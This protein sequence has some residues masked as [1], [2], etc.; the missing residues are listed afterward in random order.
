MIEL[1][2]TKK[3][4][5]FLRLFY[6]T[7][8][9]IF[10][11]F[12]IFNL[13]DTDPEVKE[14]AIEKIEPKT[15]QFGFCEDTLKH[16]TGIVKK[17]ETLS[18]ILQNL[19]V[20]LI[21]IAEIAEASKN[22]FDVRKIR[23]GKQFHIYS[24]N[25]SSNTVKY[26]IYEK[27]PINFVIY[28]LTDSIKIS[29]GKKEVVTKIVS[30]QATIDHSLYVSLMDANTS[31]ELAV[32]LSQIY[33]WQID[34]YHLQ[35]GDHFKVIYEKEFI[36]TQFVGI[37]RILG[38][39]FS[40]TGKNFYAIPFVQDSVYQYFDEDGNSLRKAFLKAPLEFSRISSRYSHRRFHPVLKRYRPHLGV[41]YA[42]PIGT[43]VR[44]TGDG[45]VIETGYKNSNGRYI[46]IKHNS[47]YTTI[48]LHLSK[49]T[50]GIKRGSHVTQ[51]QVIGYVGS[52]GLSTGP[53]L[54][55]RFYVN[56]NP[57]D[58]LKVEVPPSHP[59]KE[60]LR[61]EYEIQKLNVLNELELLDL[62]SEEKTDEPV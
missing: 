55:Y 40:S 58:P 11:L 54:D 32:K 22:I 13:L 14:K 6:F 37:G 59:V 26:F 48:Y 57:V 33:A 21:T 12:L 17:N 20:P 46:K 9:L 30:T 8:T 31:P 41:D 45:I 44:T 38:A 29:T 60:E 25:D 61:T 53:H 23:A 42:A 19:A 4:V 35:K 24:N 51:G 1:L 28:E 49:F 16:K 7:L 39:S 47:V 18:D 62:T 43:P 15:N 36:D 50:K 27:D 56:G 5:I 3:S 34:F 10:S 2:K 52:T